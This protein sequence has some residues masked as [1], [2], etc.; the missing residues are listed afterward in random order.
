MRNRSTT[1]RT[2]FT[3]TELLVAIALLLIIMISV[4][5]IFRSASDAAGIGIAITAQNRALAAVGQQFQQ[6]VTGYNDLDPSS[7]T[8]M[9]VVNPSGQDAP[10]FLFIQSLSRS[11]YRDLAAENAANRENFRQDSLGFFA[12]GKYRRQT[13]GSSLVDEMANLDDAYIWYGHLA[14]PD[15]TGW[16]NYANPINCLPGLGSRAANTHNFFAHQWILGRRAIILAGVIPALTPG[17]GTV[18]GGNYYYARPWDAAYLGETEM[19]GT[20][21]YQWDPKNFAPLGND[22]RD[23][24]I[25]SAVPS[26]PRAVDDTALAS[27]PVQPSLMWRAYM[28]RLDIAGMNREQDWEDYGRLVQQYQ[29]YFEMPTPPA[30][31]SEHWVKRYFSRPY[32]AALAEGLD[33]DWSQDS[34]PNNQMRFL[35][36]A[37]TS[38]PVML[39]NCTEFIVEFAGDY[40][41]QSDVTGALVGSHAATIDVNVPAT[42]MMD[43]VIDFDLV[44]I[45]NGGGATTR[46]IRWYGMQRDVNKNGNVD[47]DGQGDVVSVTQMRQANMNPGTWSVPFERWELAGTDFYYRAGWTQDMLSLPASGTPALSLAPKLIRLTVKVSDPQ[48]RVMDDMERQ[49]V[50]PVKYETP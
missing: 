10:P 18:N 20:D 31:Y 17:Q 15:S 43:G 33:V 26:L 42:W 22:I 21:G 32:F 3:L 4:A 11:A 1:L 35:N 34:I 41:T 19:T 49:F 28:S 37:T 12:T 38:T 16:Y 24:M 39:R 47:W 25:A 9:R 40:C 27:P 14:L 6:D 30:G 48:G 29:T 13:G 8:G 5:T 46:Q 23:G 50:F 7:G 44:P 36:T 2:A 45:P